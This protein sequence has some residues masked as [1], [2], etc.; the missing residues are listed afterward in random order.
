ML[1][2]LSGGEG[3]DEIKGISDLETGRGEVLEVSP[4]CTFAEWTSSGY[5]GN[6][7]HV[8]ADFCSLR[9]T[10]NTKSRNKD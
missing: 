6:S 5:W 10:Q 7:L 2:I 9:F 8:N 3:A 1:C 4:N